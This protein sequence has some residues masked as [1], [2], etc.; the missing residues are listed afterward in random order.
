MRRDDRLNLKSFMA[1]F[2]KR[3][4]SSLVRC[5]L[6][7]KPLRLY[8]R[9]SWREESVSLEV[10]ST[11]VA[12]NTRLIQPT[13]VIPESDTFHMTQLHTAHTSMCTLCPRTPARGGGR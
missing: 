12:R 3:Y 8:F 6:L 11:A 7:A 5:S 1:C 9:R 13:G 2:S 4:L 10:T